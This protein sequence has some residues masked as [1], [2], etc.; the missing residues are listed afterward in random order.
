MWSTTQAAY[1]DHTI[2]IVVPYSGGAVDPVA[3]MIAKE[4]TKRFNTSVIVENRPGASGSIGTAFVAKAPPDGYTILSVGTPLAINPYLVHEP[5]DWKTLV[6]IAGVY[7]T[8]QMLLVKAD[9]PFK[10]VQDLVQYAK[11]HP[12]KLTYG[13]G[14][15]GTVQRLSYELLRQSLKLDMLHVP[16]KSGID[17]VHALL[18]GQIDTVFAGTLAN[19][20]LVKSGRLRALAVSSAERS[21]VLPD[22]PTV[23][24]TLIP[25]FATYDWNGIFAP[26]KT[27][28]EIVKKL[29][30]AVI[31]IV[32]TKLTGYLTSHG[33][34]PFPVTSTEFNDFVHKQYERWGVTIKNAGIKQNR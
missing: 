2:A 12:G 24:E 10:T 31:D 26:P 27:S 9:S 17:S 8:P 21:S 29:Q 34:T 32:K 6:P 7:L 33:S 3:R 14:G 5:F 28:P 23:S 15:N 22:V 25:G 1:P 30:D 11:A 16:F 13:S 4:M 18:G 19:Q 20:G